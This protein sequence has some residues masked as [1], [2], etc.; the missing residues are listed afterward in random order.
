MRIDADSVARDTRV[1]SS[2]CTSSS[3]VEIVMTADVSSTSSATVNNGLFLNSMA[4]WRTFRV[5]RLLLV[6][7]GGFPY[8]DD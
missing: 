6:G 5:V 4:S 7:Q 8:F 3:A 1:D 2:A